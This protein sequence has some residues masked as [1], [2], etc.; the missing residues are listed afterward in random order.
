MFVHYFSFFQALGDYT[1]MINDFSV[2]P[3]DPT[4]GQVGQYWYHEGTQAY[5]DDMDH[6]KMIKAM[7]K[8]SCIVCD[9]KN[10]HRNEGSKRRAGFKNIEQLRG[11]LFH[12]HRLFMCSLCLEGRKVRYVCM[13]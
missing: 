12:Q 7:C 9:K 10:E 8:L 3:A 6:Y 5:F 2:F 1:R 13:K 11:H 4:E